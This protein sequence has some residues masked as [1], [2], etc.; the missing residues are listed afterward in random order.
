MRLKFTGHVRDLK[1]SKGKDANWGLVGQKG[2]QCK[3]ESLVKH[4]FSQEV[5]F[6]EN[7]E[8]DESSEWP[9]P[10]A[11]QQ[12]GSSQARPACRTNLVTS[13]SCRL[14]EDTSQPCLRYRRGASLPPQ[15]STQE[16][17][18]QTGYASEKSAKVGP[19]NTHHQHSLRKMCS[20][21]LFKNF[22]IS[23]HNT[24]SFYSKQTNKQNSNRFKGALS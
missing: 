14:S 12:L 2:I 19:W 17:R 16:R 8:C 9:V 23:R 21:L 3:R 24:F 11:I 20:L 6:I 22:Q 10:W 7:R 1:I 5:E 4:G 18:N 13:S 15:Y